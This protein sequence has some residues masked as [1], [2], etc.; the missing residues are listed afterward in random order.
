MKYEIVT[1][2]GELAKPPILPFD[3]LIILCYSVGSTTKKFVLLSVFIS[4]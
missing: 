2:T 3:I 1:E 4:S